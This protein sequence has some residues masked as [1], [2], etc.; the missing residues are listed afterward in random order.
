[1]TEKTVTLTECANLLLD[2]LLA[3]TDREKQLADILTTFREVERKAIREA[4][5]VHSLGGVNALIRLY[6]IHGIDWN[7]TDLGQ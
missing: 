1:M 4:A 3:E 6:A 5:F 2:R 7:R